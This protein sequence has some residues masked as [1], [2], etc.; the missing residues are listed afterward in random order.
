[1]INSLVSTREAQQTDLDA[2]LALLKQEDLPTEGVAEHLTRFLVAEDAAGAFLGAIGLEYYGGDTALLRSAVVD[3][4]CRSKGIG[5]ALFEGLLENA[6]GL[7]L[8]RLVL[9]TNTAESYFARK[10]FRKIPR[11]SITGPVTQSIEFT[12][13]CP[14]SA[15][16]MELLLSGQ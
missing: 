15:V 2:V 4:S 10:G 7:R 12:G 1:M 5:W 11:S 6:R 8:K 14:A 13:A 16:A 3:P 9:L